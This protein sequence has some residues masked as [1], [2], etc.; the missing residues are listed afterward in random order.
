MSEI[1]GPRLSRYSMNSTIAALPHLLEKTKRFP[2]LR[3][4]SATQIVR[5]SRSTAETQP[6]LHPALLR[7]SAIISQYRFTHSTLCN[8]RMPTRAVQSAIYYAGGEVRVFFGVYR[9]LSFITTA[10]PFLG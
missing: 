10:V 9:G 2:S 3:C 4:A 7:L 1:P 8:L 5:P 6:K